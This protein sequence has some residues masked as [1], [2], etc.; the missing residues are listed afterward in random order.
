MDAVLMGQVL[1]NLLDNAS[2]YSPRGSPIQISARLDEA[3]GEE[4]A[5]GLT[6]AVRDAGRGI[7]EEDLERVFDKFRRIPGGD[8]QRAGTGLGLA[9]CRGFVEAMGGTVLAA[10]R[11]DRSGAVLS[12]VVRTVFR[13]LGSLAP[14]AAA[15][16]AM[17]RAPSA[18]AGAVGGAATVRGEAL[19]MVDVLSWAMGSRW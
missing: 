11:R 8:R 14:S 7:P 19:P 3:A 4:K 17:E 6:L 16:R 9:I 2:K 5:P 18:S 1:A 15:L 12:A 13:A 10:N